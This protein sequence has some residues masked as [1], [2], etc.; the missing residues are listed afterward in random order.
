M[1]YFPMRFGSTA[2]VKDLLLD[3]FRAG[4]HYQGTQLPVKNKMG[5]PFTREMLVHGEII[6]KF[7]T[8]LA[9]EESR[10][11]ISWLI[12][13]R[14]AL[15]LI[16]DKETVLECYFPSHIDRDRY[17]ALRQRAALLPEASLSQALDVDIIENFLLGGY[18]LP[19]RC[20]VQ[21]G[22]TV[23]D[24]GV[25]N[26]NST[27]DLARRVGAHGTV[28]GFE[29]NPTMAEIARQNC[30]Q[31]NVTPRIET[32]AVGNTNGEIRFRKA[33]AAS[34][35]DPKGDIVV[36]CVTIDQYLR[37][38]QVGK[39][40]FVK[41]DIE[42]HEVPALKG[43]EETLVNHRPKI[44]VCIYHLAS[45]MRLIP[46]LIKSYHSGYKFFVRHRARHDG[47]IILF[48]VP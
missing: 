6:E 18:S 14:S 44:A 21:P 15:C 12:R 28:I 41:L 7:M 45:D 17:E 20:E 10:Q 8:E 48:C 32:M 11:I 13:F 34:R 33:G 39:I 1:N 16:G 4:L 31:M 25:F 42:G 40:D 9:D 23:L 24:L 26:G 38:H 30:A 43:M 29:P 2:S 35:I 19:D 3:G 22:N 37:E 46:L 47:E 27:I 5:A 36:P